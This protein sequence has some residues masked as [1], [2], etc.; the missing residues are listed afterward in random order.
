MTAEVTALGPFDADRQLLGLSRRRV[1][2]LSQWGARARSLCDAD[3]PHRGGAGGPLR[4]QLFGAYRP[5][6]RVLRRFRSVLPAGRLARRPL[7]SPQHDGGLLSRLR[8]LADRRGLGAIVDG[9]RHRAVHAR[10][11]CRHLSP[12]RYSHGDR[13]RDPPRTHHGV[14]RRVRQ[15]RHLACRGHY[16]DPHGRA[17]MARRIFRAGHRLCRRWHRLCVAHP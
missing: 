10:H 5:F 16:G 15:S 9:A 6:D 12:G 8:R 14:Q 1:H 7:E 2:R 11:F 4:P 17:V 3:L 13:E